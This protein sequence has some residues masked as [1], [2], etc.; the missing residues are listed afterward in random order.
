MIISTSRGTYTYGI[1]DM[2]G[3]YEWLDHLSRQGVAYT[4]AFQGQK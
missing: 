1:G 4:V 3:A 2:G